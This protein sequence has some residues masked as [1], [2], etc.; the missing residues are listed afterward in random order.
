MKK[1]HLS[2][3]IIL[4][5]S[6]VGYSQPSNDNCNS[7]TIISPTSDC[8]F[9]AA[10]L[11]NATNQAPLLNNDVW[12]SFKATSSTH[13]IGVVKTKD[14][15][16]NTTIFKPNI[17]LFNGCGSSSVVASQ[18]IDG[19]TQTLEQDKVERTYVGLT[20]GVTY[21]Y[22]VF[23]I[24]SGSTL[25]NFDTY[26]C[27]TI[28]S[29]VINDELSGAINL[30]V[31]NACN[32]QTY[33][34][35]G[36]TASTPAKNITGTGYQNADVWFKTT[37]PSN[38]SLSIFLDNLGLRGEFAIA[39][40]KGTTYSNLIEIG[41]DVYSSN[42]T[43]VSIY[44][45]GLT[46]NDVVF[47][48]VCALTGSTSRGTFK[49]CASTPPVCGSHLPAGDNCSAPTKI[50]DLNGYC[51]NTS[52]S[53]TIDEP[54]NLKS[55]LSAYQSSMSIENNSWLSFTANATSATFT[56]YVSNCIQKGAANGIQMVVLDANNCSNFV[57]HSNLWSPGT[58]DNTVLT[59]TN[60]IVGN[61]Y[62]IMVDGAAGASCD[63]LISTNSGVQLVDA[64]PDQIY[65]DPSTIPLDLNATGTGFSSLIW[66]S[67]EGGDFTPNIGLSANLS[68]N[69]G[70]T[71]TTQYIVE[72]NGTCQGTKD[73]L[74]VTVQ[75]C[76]CTKP[77]INISPSPITTCTG[78]NA[79][80]SVSVTGATS[81]QWKE[82]KD[83]GLTFLPITDGGVYS[84]SKTQTL[85]LTG[86]TSSF[87]SYQYKCI[88]IDLTGFC[89]DSTT[90]VVLSISP[91]TPITTNTIHICQGTSATVTGTVAPQAN[92]TYVWTVP[93]G[94]T[95]P[96]NVNSFTTSLAGDYTVNI[97][98]PSN[99]LCNDDFELPV[100]SGGNSTVNSASYQCWKS[101]SNQIEIWK[102][103]FVDPTTLATAK[104]FSG[105]QF[106]EINASAAGT[107]YQ[108]NLI[109][110]VGMNL[111]ISFAHRGR[112][113][114]DV[115]KVYI[116][117]S[118]GPYVLLGTYSTDKTAWV[119][120][121]VNYTVP[122]SGNYSLR[123]ESVSSFGGD[124]SYG[125]FIDA[126]SVK[127]GVC[128]IAS[129]KTTVIVDPLPSA[130]ISGTT[131]VC[132]NDPSPQVSFTGANSSPN[133]TFSY[134]IN[135]GAIQTITSV[136]NT[137]NVS[138][139]TGID[140]TYVYDL[141]SVQDAS[142]KNC[143]QILNNSVTI[144]VNETSIGGTLT[145]D[146]TI[147]S[148]NSS[149]QMNL[150][151]N[152]GNVT[153]WQS[154]IS[155]FTVWN[156]LSNTTNALISG[157]LNQTTKF[158]VIVKNETCPEVFSSQ[159]TV[160]VDPISVAGTL[161][162]DKSICINTNS[163][164]LSLNSSTGNIVKWQR[165]TSPFT[166]WI[167]ISHTANTFTSQSL[168]ETTKFQ[169][170][171]KSGVC[172]SVTSNPVT[173]SIEQQVQPTISCGT[174][175][176]NSITF[177][178]VTTQGATSH[179]YIYKIGVNG[180]WSTSLP[181]GS[182]T[183]SIG[184]LNPGITVYFTL[185]P[186]GVL[187]P[188]A[189]TIICSN[190]SQ[191][192]I[193]NATTPNDYEICIGE[194][195]T[196]KASEIPSNSNQWSISDASIISGTVLTPKDQ[197][198]VTGLIAG[199]T[200]VNF[201]NNAGCV[202]AVPITV[203]SVPIVTVNNPT[204]CNNEIA[205]ITASIQPAGNYNY[206]WTVPTGAT[207][208]GNVASFDTKVA[209]NYTVQV[210]EINANKLLLCNIDFEDNQV[211]TTGNNN[212]TDQSNIS[213]WKTTATD[214]KMEIWNNGFQSVPSYSGK[215][216]I[217]LNATQ[218]ST[219]YQVF[220]ALPGENVS[221]SFAHRG[222]SGTDIMKVEI[223]P[224]GG[225]YTTLGNYTDNNTSW[226]FYS[227]PYIFPNSA[228][229]NFELRFTA[230]SAA[231]G[232]SSGNFLDAISIKTKPTCQIQPATSTLTVNPLPI[233][234][235]GLD[236]TI[237]CVSNTTGITIGESNNASFTYSW[238]PTTGLSDPTISNP[239]ANPT[240]NETYT[241]TKTETASG[242]FDTDD[243]TV[244]INKPTVTAVAGNDGTITCVSNTSGIAIGEVTNPAYSYAWSPSTG[245]S[246]ST[247]SNPTVNPIATTTYTVTTTD[248]S[249]GCN[250]TDDVVVTINKPIV[251]VNAG[252]DDQI[253]CVVNPNGLNIGSASNVN[254]TY[255]WLP[256]TGLSDATIS[257][258]FANPSA[259]I[260]YAITAT[261]IT[262]GCTASDNIV[263][264]YNK[265]TLSSTAGNDATI[266]CV[267]NINGVTIGGANNAAYTYA[268][269]PAIGL[270]N[271]TISNPI[272]FPTSSTTYT[273]T[274]TETATG[275][276]NVDEVIITVD[277]PVI[278]AQAGND[279]T[280]TCVTN[281]SGIAIGDVTNPSYSYSWSPTLGLSNT[282]LANP[283][284]TPSTTTT[285]TLT[286]TDNATGCFGTDDVIITINKPTVIADAGTDGAI[287]CTANMTGV[288]IGEN[289]N[290]SYTYTW[291][292]NTAISDA[293]SSNPVANPTSTQSYTVTKTDIA[294]GCFDTDDV[295]ISVNKPI[296]PINAG[297]D[298][299]ITCISNIGGVS[300]GENNDVAF[301][302]AWSPSTDLSNPNISNPTALPSTTTTYTLTKTEIATGCS[303]TDDLVITINKPTISAVAGNDGIFTCI[304]NTSGVAI[305]D[306]TN[307]SY[308]YAWS[309]ISGLSSGTQS[310]P[311]AT[312]ITTTTYT[313]T[314][315]DNVT[316]CFGTDDVTI[317]VNKPT[318]VADA[319]L[320]GTITCTA[321]MTGVTI[322]E[323]S[324]ASFT[325]A[326]SPSLN[327]SD[328]SSSNP[329][330]TPST[331]QIYTVTKTDISSGCF[332]TDDVTI[333][334]NKP[335]ISVNAGN[336]AIITCISNTSGVVIGETSNSSFSYAWSP[337]TDL[338]NANS[339]NPTASPSIT[340]TFTLTK[341][342]IATGCFGTDD[343]IITLN[344]PNVNA[345]AGND[346][347]ITC[348]TN[349]TGVTIGSANNVSYSYAWSP[350]T[351]LSSTT[352][353]NPLA[354]PTST[355]TY[356]VTT[357]DISSGC[358][359]TD[360]VI[361]SVDKVIPTADAGNDD[362]V[363]CISGTAPLDGIN[364]TSGLDYAWTT[365]GLDAQIGN[366]S[367]QTTTTNKD[368]I[369]TLTVTNPTNGC[370][371]TDQ[372]AISLHTYP[373]LNPTSNSPICENQDLNLISNASANVIYQWS[374]PNGFSSSSL[375]PTIPSAIPSASGSYTLIVTDANGCASTKTISSTVN[376][377]PTVSATNS[378]PI[379]ID[380]ASFTVNEKLGNGVSWNW[381]SNGNATI[382]G[383]SMKNP[384]I[385]NAVDGEI[386]TLTLTD[387]NGCVNT[388]N[389]T[390]KINKLPNIIATNSGPICANLVSFSLNETGGDAI[391]WKWTKSGNAT[392]SSTTQKNPTVTTS[393]TNEIFTVEGKDINGCVS[394][395]MTTVNINPLPQFTL[396]DNHPCDSAT[397]LLTTNYPNAKS[398]LW[399]G[400]N[401]YN[402][403]IQNPIVNMADIV[404]F[405]GN[406]SLKVTDNNDCSNTVNH[407]VDIIAKDNIQF[408]I[409]T[410]MCQHDGSQ[411]LKANFKGTWSGDGITNS[412]TGLFSPNSPS[413][414]FMPSRNVVVF[415]SE[416]APCPNIKAAKINLHKNPS[417]DFEGN[418]EL[419]EDDTLSLINLSSPL[420]AKFE[421]D[422]GNGNKSNSLNPKYVYTQGG[423]YTIQLKATANGCDSTFSKKDYVRVV[424]KPTD[425]NFTT[426]KIEIDPLFPEVFFTTTT[427]ANFYTWNFGDGTISQQKNPIHTFP[428]ESGEY[429]VTLTASSFQK[430]CSNV[431]KHAILVLE[432]TLYYIPNTFTPN[433]D[434]LNNLFQPVFTSGYDPMHYSFYIYNRWGELIFETHNPQIGWDGTFGNNLLKNDTFIW[435]LEFKEKIKD[436]RHVETGHVN[437][438][439]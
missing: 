216:F 387:A 182:T 27:E 327:L 377:L 21:Y 146:H 133:Y 138:V 410:A 135:N 211:T 197:F 337:S 248:I 158:R 179:T 44:K 345:I 296:I 100:I 270:S 292:P 259:T 352:T 206:T 12:F 1:N 61:D 229:G 215:Q 132:K 11:K 346:S 342:E 414:K 267:A 35:T 175:N 108:D 273:L 374:G 165:S 220:S 395:A 258:P 325:Y 246:S 15:N 41:S 300:I 52:A 428:T 316:G 223:G 94:F 39:L 319:G 397:L 305:G 291:S 347:P 104:A 234:N 404:N 294:S 208:P 426:N 301:S 143:S 336:D 349:I 103:G 162:S 274:T 243:V 37:V 170:V 24:G 186:V 77:I 74:L 65:C 303:G 232:I 141:L 171:V 348:V 308:S 405:E 361:V 190:C 187:C 93:A 420:S 183:Q 394:T 340:T 34:I 339:S 277:K 185:T 306:L 269:S 87:N 418:T 309:P 128:S 136:G 20:I 166:S 289:S 365:G 89:S 286:T 406:Y 174:S 131:T 163:G 4:L 225:P 58:V 102:T 134:S 326:W 124:Q 391:S 13:S 432:P 126:I 96:G 362:F 92:Y 91:L 62:L 31:T 356:S 384:T 261:E 115:M 366:I 75:S 16:L 57:R 210:S 192:T 415:Q 117:P 2:L 3:F 237:T 116:G 375:N 209:G 90:G 200:D 371:S 367:S 26:I 64:G 264:T 431:V 49:I 425:V 430:S 82:S 320:D 358:Y 118:G 344:K 290:A 417:V 276:T 231:G 204:V 368:G 33:S 322:G 14:L 403:T 388:A 169:S 159:V 372:V 63:Y 32:L 335:I 256:T 6:F 73:S 383:A 224:V 370:F 257:N 107:L 177:D 194:T 10:T 343:V 293:T 23:N 50:C 161:S 266:T 125:N 407:L 363:S 427:E 48:R 354:N 228:S 151:G 280:I 43:T 105:N 30:N 202:N 435:K 438:I 140:G 302:Y 181:N 201:I 250:N 332:D 299:T 239:I 172:P 329:T 233:A 333:S 400:P 353:S 318:V 324:N 22:R 120:Y 330:V 55:L 379:C 60:L 260:T 328:A 25:F 389:T 411:L 314:T 180:T 85:V 226:G 253:T 265:P 238:T 95:N 28:N 402:S 401:G 139:P 221:I 421:W 81:Y 56:I 245:L 255:A 86:L 67:R 111:S 321:N 40:Y 173:I 156:D 360:D 110:N 36:S 51:G 70:P 310:N 268:W 422:F 385:T 249:S 254:Y 364:S 196:L 222:R 315:T 396:S 235:A 46:P 119:L 275:C 155:P 378:G 399:N 205:T 114:I 5:I 79:S 193:S 154:S 68:L 178:W 408:V 284:A 18:A 127:T 311:T 287:T 350:S 69:P 98:T 97:F 38:G 297:T 381:S 282:T 416:G 218:A 42:S 278:T 198:S 7:A 129:S 386:F 392:F 423:N 203:I 160:T 281:T 101:T 288:T 83:G 272:A 244:T 47:I 122:L 295:S 355:T 195:V 313:L 236:G 153:K 80:F 351:G 217:E 390:V 251:T 78:S 409:D 164:L 88:A 123:F 142:S 437:L 121:N 137:A 189:A 53:Y 72:A 76:L 413:A 168:N 338:T 227:V 212:I 298:A 334:V 304:T 8:A 109:L 429:L 213:C 112:K 71:K 149:S 252:N 241:V 312:P 357:T 152:N 323:N 54:S 419:C 106:I 398:Y 9:N 207:N 242:C 369:Y 373:T 230:V 283:S 145:S 393:V 317:N 99:L 307:P 434:E 380:A 359:S 263:I 376:P 66:S 341:T 113:G 199:K 262:S 130:T 17:E 240:T 247:V 45:T 191:P 188:E 19:S 382:T 219:I 271:S 436:I 331:N 279:G 433:G 285:Y 412:I 214:K 424:S 147:C 176:A 144:I 29:G 439:R 184:G 157:L 59:A 150:N 148:G 167:D 84:G